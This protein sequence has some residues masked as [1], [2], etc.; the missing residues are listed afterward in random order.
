[1]TAQEMFEALGYSL[2]I[3]KNGN[4]LYSQPRET[5]NRHNVEFFIKSKTYHII[6]TKR[7]S[8]NMELH[9][10]IQKQIEELNW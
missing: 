8:I 7:F 10:A 4:Y 2:T 9:K 6:G 5:Q 1:M 3:C